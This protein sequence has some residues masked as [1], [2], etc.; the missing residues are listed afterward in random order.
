MTN[1]NVERL[2]AAYQRWDEVKGSDASCWTD[3]ADDTLCL[4]SIGDG[5]PGIEFSSSCGSKA[6]AARYFDRLNQDWEMVF[7]RADDFVAEGDR[8]VVLGACA[9]RNRTTGQVAETPKIDIWIFRDGRA[10]SFYELF[11]TARV[12]VAAGAPPG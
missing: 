12:Q 5:R 9:W 8:V 3:L 7:A 6:E 11:D 1:A 10:V 4:G 2:R